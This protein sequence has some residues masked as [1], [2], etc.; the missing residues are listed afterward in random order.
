MLSIT[1]LVVLPISKVD[2]RVWRP[3]S[4]RVVAIGYSERL[5]G[6]VGIRRMEAAQQQVRLVIRLDGGGWRD[7]VESLGT[8][9]SVPALGMEG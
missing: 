8:S 4:Q 1:A 5:R 6:W 7:V 9:G 3:E 2:W